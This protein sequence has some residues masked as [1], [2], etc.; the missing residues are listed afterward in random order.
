MRRRDHK[1]LTL[2]ELILALAIG[3]M[4]M[5]LVYGF[6]HTMVSSDAVL[7]DRSSLY[8]DLRLSFNAMRDDLA[9][10]VAYDFSGSY[11]DR[12]YFTADGRRMEFLA[13][14]P[15]GINVV[16]YEIGRPD[17][18]KKTKVIVGKTVK[19]IQQVI[20]TTKMDDRVFLMRGQVLL[21]DALKKPLPVK[22]DQIL[23]G[24]FGP[25]ALSWQFLTIEDGKTQTVEA[26]GEKG[27][28]NAV[29]VSMQLPMAREKTRKIETLMLLPK[30]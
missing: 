6:W 17:W 18:G 8:R 9:R 25:S 10:A 2:I 26:W 16:A 20:E 30:A 13:V 12:R 19:N 24:P 21:S 7:K 11:P 29:D 3:L 5:S 1:G 22:A 28:P 23:F 15:D 4:V 14:F 27:F